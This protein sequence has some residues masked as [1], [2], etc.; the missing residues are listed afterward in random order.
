MITK[1]LCPALAALFLA[2]MP[3]R[4]AIPPAENLLPTDTLAF[5]AVPDCAAARTDAK[6]SPGWMFWTDPAMRSFREKMMAKW[7]EQFIAPLEHDLGIKVAD[8]MDLPQGQFTVA[9]TVNGAT[10]HDDTPPGMLLLLDARDKSDSLKTNLAVLVKKWTDAGRALRTEAIHGLSFTVVPLASN[11]LA[12]LVPKK[13][14]T[15]ELG[16]EP[17]KPAKPG[18]IYFVQ[19][20]T[21]LVVGNS[22]KV[23]EPIAAHLTGGSEPAL[24]DNAAFAADKVSQFRDNPQYYGWFNGKAFLNLL[25]QVSAANEEDVA[26]PFPSSSITKTLGALGLNSVRSASLALRDT[27][28]GS[29]FTVHVTAPESERAGLLKILALPPKDASV[30]PFVPA[31]AVKFTRVRLD[32]KQTWAEIEKIVANISPSGQASLNAIIG[33]ANSLGQQKNPGFDLRTDLIGNLGD[34]L[35]TYQ[36]PV[37]GNSLD[38]LANPPILF[39]FAVSNPD[40]VLN[41]IKTLV[42]ISSSQ[43]SDSAPREFLGRK[44]YSI[45]LKAGGAAAGGTTPARTL[46]LANSSGYLALSTDSP[47]LEEFLRN[48]DGKNQP[49]RENAALKAALQHLGGAG[50]G[51]FSYENQR[52]T[53]RLTFKA[54][55]DTLGANSSDAALKMLSPNLREWFDFSLLPD[56]G[57]VSKYFYISTFVGSANSEGMTFRAFA[58]R[59]PQLN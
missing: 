13:T 9:V 48:A 12:G 6:S 44:I 49:L 11:D 38:D 41:A 51:M 8:F 34:D 39:L 1:L 55:K 15:A 43:P 35:I 53:M 20:Q 30:P 14:P 40:A 50:G 58:P 22:A 37:A 26:S 10:G 2:V 24:A 33:F 3:V 23:V 29:V 36:K 52:E 27:R 28:E 56:Y 25:S 18:E 46:Y 42:A 59:P 17:E 31:D 47:I 4:A 57:L 54:V 7:N 21:L 5:F 32:G 16:K 45:P 19:F